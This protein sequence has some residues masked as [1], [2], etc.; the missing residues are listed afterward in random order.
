MTVRI[1]AGV[2]A[3]LLAGCSASRQPAAV[4]PPPSAAELAIQGKRLLALG[5]VDSA[6]AMLEQALALDSGN[7]QIRRD[8][9]SALY[10]STGGGDT[11]RAA[12]AVAAY[13]W[14]EERGEADVEV[15]DRLYELGQ[16]LGDTGAVLQT[17][18]HAAEFSRAGAAG[19]PRDVDL[20]R[21]QRM[22]RAG[23]LSDH[24]ALFYKET[25]SAVEP[26]PAGEPEPA[27]FS[28]TPKP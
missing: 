12:A 15:Y 26:P 19:Q 8:L 14:L 25:A 7:V 2:L 3:V 13:R 5:E 11:A 9:A 24:E 20:D 18:R 16:T 6:R 27:P 21:I 10:R 28:P 22:I 23:Q 4:E 1:T 17:A